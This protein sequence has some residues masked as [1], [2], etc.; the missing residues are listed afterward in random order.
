MLNNNNN[1]TKEKNK[2][3]S[4][5][6]FMQYN[7]CLEMSLSY[8]LTKYSTTEENHPCLIFYKEHVKYK[9]LAE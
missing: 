5:Y 3:I 6:F 4:E 8:D 1:V 7:L 9:K 2:F